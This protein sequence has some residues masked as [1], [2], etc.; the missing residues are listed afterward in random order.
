MA[1]GVVANASL[2]FW[3]FLDLFLFIIK[4]IPVELNIFWICSV[5]ILNK[6]RI[7]DQDF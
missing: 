6:L 7:F 4:L 2:M 5:Q 3:L 1:V